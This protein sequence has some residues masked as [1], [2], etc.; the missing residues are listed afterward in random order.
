MSSS[1]GFLGDLS[2]EQNAALTAFEELVLTDRTLLSSCCG[3]HGSSEKTKSGERGANNKP[4][5]WQ[6]DLSEKS[7]SRDIIFL[8]FLRAE[9]FQVEKSF[10]RFKDTMQWR[11]E[12]DVDGLAEAHLPE[13]FLNHDIFYGFDITGA[14]TVGGESAAAPAG[15]TGGASI[16][17]DEA[18]P[19]PILSSHFGNM[20][21]QKVF[22][23]TDLF[24]KYRVA[25]MERAIKRLLPFQRGK[26]ETLFQ[27]HDYKDCP[28]IFKDR[29]VDQGVK[30]ISKILGDHYPEF[31][32][33]T[34]FV[35]FPDIV[36]LA[37]KAAA[38]LLVPE[39]TAKK[40]AF[41][42]KG[43]LLP[44]LD[45]VP[46]HVLSSKLGGLVEMKNVGVSPDGAEATPSTLFDLSKTPRPVSGTIELSARSGRL[47]IPL[48]RG[49]TLY[50]RLRAAFDKDSVRIS[51]FSW[52]RCDRAGEITQEDAVPQSF[53]ETALQ[54]QDAGSLSEL[55]L[56]D[57]VTLLDGR[58]IFLTG[59]KLDGSP[60]R[61]DSVSLFFSDLSTFGLSRKV[62]VYA[63]Q[64]FDDLNFSS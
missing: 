13:Q 50:L 52:S 19:R 14:S 55:S 7:D 44:L 43:D 20:D 38:L 39:K 22:G 45:D 21:L 23:N 26:A 36:A 40:L 49:Q 2:P 3:G 8:K 29:S 34:C 27:I 30:A 60:R 41:L 47:T 5:L 48:R 18:K 12:N 16:R 28:V 62:I 31:K 1:S 61:S 32:G 17:H 54:H 4:I 51:G 37:W 33:K 35:N 11:V 10:Q 57:P 64:L 53:F 6:C 15:T 42:G 24:V 25:I 46:A 9:E 59:E 56:V 63:Y 58:K